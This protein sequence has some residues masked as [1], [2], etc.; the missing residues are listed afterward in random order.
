MSAPVPAFDAAGNL[1]IFDVYNFRIRK[2]TPSGIITTVAGGGSG[3]DG[4]P[5]TSAWVGGGGGDYGG[6]AADSLGNL[7]LAGLR[8]LIPTSRNTEGCLYSV[9]PTTTQIGLGGGSLSIDVIAARTDC[10]W[11]ATS[12]ASWLP[13]P[14]S[15]R[16]GN[17]TVTITIPANPAVTARSAELGIA[18]ATV[19]VTQAGQPV[20]PC[21]FTLTPSALTVGSSGSTGSIAIVASLPEC[22]W[23]ATTSNNWVFLTGA[24]AGNGSGSVAYAV[25]ANNSTA[26]RTG[27]LVVAG[28]TVNIAQAGTATPTFTLNPTSAK[29]RSA[30]FDAAF[31]RYAVPAIP[32]AAKR[33][34]GR[35]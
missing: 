1:Y 16:E 30:I 13:L 21:A 15:V 19:G 20:Q 22:Q 8:K 23:T 2:V 7:Y 4:G 11:L 25:A 35:R 29:S 28:I 27:S 6:L 24:T 18:G 26:S 31:V 12:K 14:E 17:G 34:N 3:G 9:V 33:K 5:A 32:K 10:P